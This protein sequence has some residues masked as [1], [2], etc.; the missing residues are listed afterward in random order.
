MRSLGRVRRVIPE[1][2]P[3]LIL[4]LPLFLSTLLYISLPAAERRIEGGWSVGQRFHRRNVSSRH[5]FRP[6]QYLFLFLFQLI[7]AVYNLQDLDDEP[8]N[9][10]YF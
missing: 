6:M 8:P 5:V 10:G 7:G 9:V 4:T 2:P 1:P 3:T